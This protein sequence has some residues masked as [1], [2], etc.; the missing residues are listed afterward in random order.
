MQ[1]KNK[2]ILITGGNSGIGMQLV[3]QLNLKDNQLIIASR[4]QKHWDE[5]RLLQ[6]SVTL[7]Q[8][9]LSKKAEVL[10]LV[11]QLKDNAIQPDVLINCAA[12]QNTPMMTDSNF[13]FDDIETEIAT[14][15]T[16]PVWLSNLLLPILLTRPE[17]AIVNLSSGL[18]LFPKSTSAVYCATKAA[19][20]NLSQSLR[21]Q[22]AEAP[23]RIFEAILPLVD[24]PMTTGRGSGKMSSEQAA[25]NIIRGI[26]RDRY[27]NYI[28]KAGWLP[29]LT[30]VWPGLVK[31]ILRKY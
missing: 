8:S 3:K 9:D 11:Q 4:S 15:F 25:R 14:N 13:V 18:A 23:V 20:H 5:L 29:L 19:L 17:A 21:Y 16:A 12:I 2:S 28:G 30:R 31:R 22:L 26:E 7:F 1:L 27:E 24:T 10:Q 6:P